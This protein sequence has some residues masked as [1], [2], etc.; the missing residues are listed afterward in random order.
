MTVVSTF[1]QQRLLRLIVAS[2]TAVAIVIALIVGIRVFSSGESQAFALPFEPGQVVHRVVEYETVDPTTGQA[3]LRRERS[4]ILVS[5]DRTVSKARFQ[6]MDRRGAIIQDG[7]VD[8]DGS[9]AGTYFGPGQPLEGQTLVRQADDAIPAI[10]WTDDAIER[11]LLDNGFIEIGSSTI[12]GHE[13]QVYER[14]ASFEFT[15]GK[16]EEGVTIDDFPYFGQFVGEA[17]VVHR[18]Y[19]G[20]DPK[21]VDLGEEAFYRDSRANEFLSFARRVTT[22][23]AMDK[24]AAPVGIFEWP[25]FSQPTD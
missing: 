5:D 1:I 23:E 9:V 17:E 15:G 16:P 18:V 22:L 3:E 24:S 19:V 7:Y 14:I 20:I 6:M 13:A 11:T 2:A 8:S 25:H 10:M 12:A 21:G 4:W